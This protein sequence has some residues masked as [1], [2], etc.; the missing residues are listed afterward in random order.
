MAVTHPLAKGQK[1]IVKGEATVC[2]ECGV[3]PGENE[4]ES[5]I[6]SV[7]K[8]QNGYWYRVD[9]AL[10]LVAEDMIVAV[11]GGEEVVETV[12]EPEPAPVVELEPEVVE[13]PVVEP[14]PTPEPEVVEELEEEKQYIFDPEAEAA[15]SE[16]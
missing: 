10:R 5:V 6:E 8:T 4:V 13:E 9:T 2:Y 16:E 3:K 12:V 7:S 15:A 1:V 14:E 11:V